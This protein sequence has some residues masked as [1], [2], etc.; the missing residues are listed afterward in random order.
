VD[1][2]SKCPYLGLLS[3][4][5]VVS[6]CHGNDVPENVGP[7]QGISSNE[8]QNLTNFSL[9]HLANPMSQLVLIRLIGASSRLDITLARKTHP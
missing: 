5:G 7:N 3:R 4:I 8:T 9:T 2:T 6:Q 1:E